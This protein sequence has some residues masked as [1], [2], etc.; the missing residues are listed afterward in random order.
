MS[1]FTIL[2]FA[3]IFLGSLAVVYGQ[4]RK[5]K[6]IIVIDPGHGGPDTGAVGVNGI[7]EKEVA[8]KIAM[9]VLRLNKELYADTL[10]VYSTRY[11][12]TLIPLNHRTKLAKALAA[13]VY[14]S[15]H[16]NQSTISTAQ[17]AEVYIRQAN[18]ISELLAN[19][20][21][22][23]LH[24]RLGYKNR[25]VH[26]GDF[27]VLQESTDCPSVLLELG[28]LSNGSEAEHSAKVSSVSALALLF[29]ETLI[30]FMS[31]D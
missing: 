7:E 24:Q 30:E 20:F 1:R 27:Q 25:G 9:E 4:E 31:Y 6:H 19:Q 23:N 17:G 5:K 26:Y 15:I 12:D 2:I 13:D 11:T 21:L 8:L 16:C 29:L 3:Y 14:V 10:E 22:E 28:Y 18:E